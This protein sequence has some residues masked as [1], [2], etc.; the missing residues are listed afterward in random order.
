MAV[1]F[2]F[3][4]DALFNGVLRTAWYFHSRMVQYVDEVLGHLSGV[5]AL[6]IVAYGIP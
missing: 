2:E 3:L 4:Y 1:V 5:C 6:H